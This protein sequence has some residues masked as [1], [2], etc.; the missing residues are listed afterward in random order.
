[1]K[2]P[3][4]LLDA[5]L[6]DLRERMGAAGLGIFRLIVNPYRF[7]IG[8]LE[9]LILDGI[10]IRFLDEVRALPDGTLCYKDRRV[11][12]FARDAVDTGR[13]VEERHDS[14]RYHVANCRVVR[15]ARA[16]D[17]AIADTVLAETGSAGL[18]SAYKVS[19][20]EDGDLGLSVC[21]EC[22]GE[23]AFDGYSSAL[24]PRERAN[25]LEG[26]TLTRFF[27]RYRRALAADATP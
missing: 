7:T 17:A 1:M 13:M 2:L 21:A 24:E 27:E 14:P 23:L 8:E 12:L 5:A 16:L 22:L 26:F 20:R 3:N 6:N 10:H 25:L 4:F 11:A 9:D 18:V 19:A 15:E